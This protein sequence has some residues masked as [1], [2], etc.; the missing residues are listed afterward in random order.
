MS[1]SFRKL[2]KTIGLNCNKDCMLT[3]TSNLLIR[4]QIS[5]VNVL[6]LF[7]SSNYNNRDTKPKQAISLAPSANLKFIV[8]VAL[9]YNVHC[10]K[11][12]QT[13]KPP[14][15]CCF[16][17]KNQLILLYRKQNIFV[18]KKKTMMMLLCT[19]CPQITR[20]HHVHF[21][22]VLLFVVEC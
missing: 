19:P 2:V 1:F 14:V 10:K 7:P 18:K 17:E 5:K 8:L 6:K 13:K 21:N 9:V 12:Q 15:I 4:R 3:L 11:Q 22:Y 20:Q 16:L